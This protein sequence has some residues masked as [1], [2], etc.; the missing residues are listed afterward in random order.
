MTRALDIAFTMLLFAS[1]VG[2]FAMAIYAAVSM[3]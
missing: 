3:P 2:G 1:I